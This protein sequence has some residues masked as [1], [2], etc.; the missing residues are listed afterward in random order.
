MSEGD[1][2][3]LD[4]EVL[5]D[6]ADFPLSEGRDMLG[7]TVV[8]EFHYVTLFGLTYRLRNQLPSWGLAVA[9]RD[10][11]I[12]V[13]RSVQVERKHRHLPGLSHGTIFEH[14]LHVAGD[15]VLKGWCHW[16]AWG[17]NT[18]GVLEGPLISLFYLE[19]KI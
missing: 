13:D 7:R 14:E 9:S 11:C 16:A 4:V 19:L 2:R 18:V 8:K 15:D 10:R 6:A 3:I 5:H 1:E 12:D 17:D